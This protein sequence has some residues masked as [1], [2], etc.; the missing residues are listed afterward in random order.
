MASDRPKN[1]EKTVQVADFA[2]ST[3]MQPD[4]A[5]SAG[6]S[7]RKNLKTREKVTEIVNGPTGPPKK[8]ITNLLV[9]KVSGLASN[10]KM[11]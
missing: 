5:I 3:D 1:L 2:L 9:T 7:T 10:L 4:E 8:V 11:R 6:R